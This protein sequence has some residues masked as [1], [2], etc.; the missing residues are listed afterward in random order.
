MIE[1]S[2]LY[3]NRFLEDWAG[4][5]MTNILSDRENES[6]IDKRI[7]SPIKNYCEMKVMRKNT[8]TGT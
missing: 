6:A 8:R 1:E 5:I 2:P 3:E 4:S 7:L